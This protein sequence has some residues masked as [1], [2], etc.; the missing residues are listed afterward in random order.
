ME[1]WKME[2]HYKIINAKDFIKAHPTGEIDLQQSKDILTEI[3]V[4]AKPP[5]DYDILLDAREVYGNLNYGEIFELVSVF[6]EHRTSF[7][8]KIALLARDD[9]QFDNANFMELCATNRGFKV[10]AFTDFEETINWLND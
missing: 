10:A 7:R 4:M 5:A 8:N 9:K 3:A 1:F 6:G 2:A